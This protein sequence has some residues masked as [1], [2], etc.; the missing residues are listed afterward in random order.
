VS[1]LEAA[2]H[3]TAGPL[4][5]MVHLVEPGGRGGVFQHTV[6]WARQLA[7][8][9]TKAIIHTAEDH[10]DLGPQSVRFCRCVRWHRQIRPRSHRAAWIVSDYLARSLS[11]LRRECRDEVVHVQGL[12]GSPLYAVTVAALRQSAARVVFSPHNTFSRAGRR[13]EETVLRWSCRRADAV[14]VFSAED[15]KAVASWGSQPVVCPLVQYTPPGSA[16]LVARWKDRLQGGTPDPVVVVPGQ[17]RPDKG[18]E[19]VLYAAAMLPRRPTISVVGEDKGG[20]YSSKLVAERLGLPVTWVIGY[21]DMD[22][23]AAAIR[24]ADVVVAPYARASQSGVLALACQL[25]TPSIAFP[26]GGL[27]EYATITTE[28]ADVD[29]LAEA[30]ACFFEGDGAP[31]PAMPTL[32][33]CLT[34]LY[35]RE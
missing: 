10:E 8:F 16:D 24:A 14:V 25:G 6:E 1:E 15:G 17:I 19:A 22:D 33:G 23:F 9:G 32:K 27:A 29:S 18:I 2:E 3:R 31:P 5:S 12:F 21:Q 28:R 13:Y 26:T 11:H 20:L 35:A 7:Q 30:M 4:A 34:G